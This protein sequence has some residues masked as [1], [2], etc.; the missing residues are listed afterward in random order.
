MS[1]HHSDHMSQGSQVSQS[2][3]WECFSKQSCSK[4]V[5]DEATYRAVPL[6]S[7]GQLKI[8]KMQKKK[9]RKFKCKQEN[10][11]AKKIGKTDPLGLMK[12]K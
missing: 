8:N 4:L 12:I 10:R 6:F 2:A 1:P 3:L 9:S 11:I 5:S 7:E